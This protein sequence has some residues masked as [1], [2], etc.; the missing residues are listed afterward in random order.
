MKA[1]GIFAAGEGSR[2]SRAFPG[3]PKPLLPVAG[4]P[5]CVWVARSLQRAGATDIT[6]LL[7]T[8]GAAARRILTRALPEVR[9]KFIVKNTPASWDSFR[10]VCGTLAAHPAFLLT[11]TDALIPGSE[12]ARFAGRMAALGAGL[13]LGLTRR[14]DDD[15][16]LWAELSP[17]GR[18]TALGPDCRRKE[19]ATAG[20]Y[21]LSGA[22]ARALPRAGGY[23]SLRE[24]LTAAVRGSRPPDGAGG[25]HG[26]KIGPTLDVDRPEDLPAAESFVRAAACASGNIGGAGAYP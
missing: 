5:L 23:S 22:R 9:W 16:P 11:T 17:A 25:L 12:T 8:R 15:K 4:T 6:M 2:L 24:Y 3:T 21:Y 26:L 14:I 7:I 10:L 20:L 18:V 1:A 13:G 19:L